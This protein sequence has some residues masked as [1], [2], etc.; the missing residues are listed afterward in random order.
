MVNGVQ[1]PHLTQ[2]RTTPKGVSRQ[3]VAMADDIESIA[4]VA[5]MKNGTIRPLFSDQPVAHLSL[6]ATVLTK[7][8]QDALQPRPAPVAAMPQFDPAL[9]KKAHNG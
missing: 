1:I 3:L 8:A 4:V 5:V 7:A 6:C 9:L 2:Q